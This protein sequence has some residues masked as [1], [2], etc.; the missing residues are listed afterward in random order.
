MDTKI[1][2]GWHVLYVRLSQEKKVHQALIEESVESF[3]PLNK[4]VKQWSDRKKTILTP[5]FPS[6]LFVNIKSHLDFHKVTRMESCAFLRFG[7]ELGRISQKEIEQIKLF[8]SNEDI[9]EITTTSVSLPNVGDKL[10]IEQGEL[11]GFECEVYRLD[12]KNKVSVWLSSL[13]QN[14]SATIPASYLQKI[15]SIQFTN[16]INSSVNNALQ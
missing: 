6:Y 5:L 11:S 3:L 2:K 1:K 10:K 7:S 12:N 14:I 15:E 4:T 8:T 9:T 16:K 13:R